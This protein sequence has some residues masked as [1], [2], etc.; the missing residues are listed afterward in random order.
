MYMRTVCIAF[1]FA[2]KLTVHLVVSM[3]GVTKCCIS[4]IGT[5]CDPIEYRRFGLTLRFGVRVRF[6]A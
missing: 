5:K 3:C 2:L 4:C 1:A 6:S